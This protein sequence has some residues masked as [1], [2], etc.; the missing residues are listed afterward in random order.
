MEISIRPARPADAD[1]IYGML[2]DLENTALARES[3][4]V[5]F[6]TN[7]GN[8]NIQYLMAEA[9]GMLVGMASCHVQ[10]L[11]HHAAP[12]AEIQEMYVDPTLRS[13]GIGNKLIEAIRHFAQARGA[14]QIEV[15]SNLTRLNT[16]R[17]Y[18]REGFQ[19][20]HAKLVMKLS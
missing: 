1:P 7:L 8:E 5:A 14:G 3:F 12:V 2:C 15:T 17:F 10:W 19:K 16:H 6:L 9:Q 4:D 11:L 18:E 13:Q 20:T